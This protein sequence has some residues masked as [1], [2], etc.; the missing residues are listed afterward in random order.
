MSALNNKPFSYEPVPLH[1]DARGLV[2][3]PIGQDALPHQANAHL[4]VTEPG[5]IRGN[6]FHPRGAEILVLLGPGLVRVRLEEGVKDIEVPEGQAYR[7]FLPPGVA[8]AIKNTG[9]RPMV[10][11]GFNT[12]A[13]DQNQPDVVR[14]VLI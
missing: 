8:H 1:R 12:Q 11:I 10:L 9:D 5:G 6:H 3:E 2:V 14:D 13:H 4:V 7:F